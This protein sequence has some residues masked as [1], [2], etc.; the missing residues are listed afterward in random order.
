M[1]ASME[2][3]PRRADWENFIDFVGKLIFEEQSPERLLIV[4]SKLYELLT[5][6]IPPSVVLKCLVLALMR[7][8]D[9]SLQ[10]EIAEWAAY[11]DHRM[12]LGTKPIFHL[13]A[14]V[15][16]FMSIY[17]KFVIETFG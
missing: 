4:R 7:R 8:V 12:A 6:C 10:P 3:H 9:Q 1:D 11:Y 17:K 15:A 14:F 2:V 16:K 13:E 5:N